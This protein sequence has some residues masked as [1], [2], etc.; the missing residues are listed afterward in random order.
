MLLNR[1]DKN[2]KYIFLVCIYGVFYEKTARKNR[3]VALFWIYG[4][5]LPRDH[6]GDGLRG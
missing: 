3:V 4:C 2:V 1:I 5:V 6:S